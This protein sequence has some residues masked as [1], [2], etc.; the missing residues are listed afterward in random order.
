MFGGGGTVERRW[1]ARDA[2]ARRSELPVWALVGGSALGGGAG[3]ALRWTGHAV[4]EAFG[5][6]LTARQREVVQAAIEPGI[7]MHEAALRMGMYRSTFRRELFR[8]GA[9]IRRKMAAHPMS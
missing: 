9:R 1:L 6:L 4:L 5:S 2:R 7:S 8:A 3:L